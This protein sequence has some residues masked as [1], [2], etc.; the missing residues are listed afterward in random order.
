MSRPLERAGRAFLVDAPAIIVMKAGLHAGESLAE[1]LVRKQQEERDV[2]VA[3]WGY[4]G[5]LCRPA[6]VREFVS[7]RSSSGGVRAVMP[8]TASRHRGGA[9]EEA[10]EFSGDGATWASLPAGAHV[11]GSGF[12]LVLQD[13]HY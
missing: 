8:L 3:C 4:N 9:G 11:R 5:S 10:R 12:A 1:I 7:G 6:Q 13:L 2:G